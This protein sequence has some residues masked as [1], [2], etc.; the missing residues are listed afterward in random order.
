MKSA[1][2][3]YRILSDPVTLNEAAKKLGVTQKTVQRTLMHLALT[4]KDFTY[5]NFGILHLFWKECEGDT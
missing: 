4:R 1:R 2:A 3:V 5:T